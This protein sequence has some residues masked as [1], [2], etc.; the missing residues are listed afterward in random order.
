VKVEVFNLQNK[1]WVDTKKIKKLLK[2]LMDYYKCGNKEI[3]L[4]LVNNRTIKK[5]NKKFLK[6]NY[7]TD[8]LSFPLDE[9]ILNGSYYLGDIAISVPQAFK[10][11]FKLSHGLERELELLTI[12]GF[13]HLLGFDHEKDKGEMKAEEEKLKRIFLIDKF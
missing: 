4:I 11:C 13:L 10:Q 12:H 3:T 5:L 6:R 8:V 7:P 9:K 1:Y 2:N